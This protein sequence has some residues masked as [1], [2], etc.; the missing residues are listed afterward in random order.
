MA[1]IEL[2]RPPA[3][4]KARVAQKPEP[5]VAR[6]VDLP[7]SDA[8]IDMTTV[9]GRITW[10]RFRADMTQKGLAK[11]AQKVRPTIAAYESGRIEPPL[12]MIKKLA[13]I[14]R[15]SPSLLAFGEHG[16]KTPNPVE[17]MIDVPEITIGRDGEHQSQ[18]FGMPRKLIESYARDPKYVRAYVLDHGAP[19]FNL[20]SGDRIFADV[21][22][23]AINS[24][25]DMYLLR[26]PTG[27]EI[28]QIESGLTDETN[29]VSMIGPRGGSR[30][31]DP[32][33]LDIIGA[34]VGTLRQS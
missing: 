32:T 20:S 25:N 15:V 28:M 4:K 27:M 24:K 21:S 9:G 29:M 18:T 33:K 19:A 26:T 11:L 13:D 8:D 3:K 22:V 23:S 34:V 14:L 10:A 17:S 30:K 31:A 12:E 16:T 7:K 6:R 2:V 1:T 5:T